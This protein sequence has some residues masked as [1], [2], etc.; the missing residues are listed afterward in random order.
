MDTGLPKRTCVLVARGH[1]VLS[2]EG[3]ELTLAGERFLCSF[4]V[5]LAPPP[6]RRI[7][8]RPCLD[9]SERRWHIKGVV[10]ARMLC[11]CMKLGWFKRERDT[12]ALR[13]T[14]AGTAGLGAAISVLFFSKHKILVIN[15]RVVSLAPVSR[16]RRSFIPK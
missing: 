14:P 9:W 13:P 8:C 15:Q 2:D 16:R 7:Y 1:V 10:G 12:R 6:S 5:D 3:G 11:R 4:G